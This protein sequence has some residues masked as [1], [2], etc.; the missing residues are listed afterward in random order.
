VFFVPSLLTGAGNLGA[1]RNWDLFAAPSVAPALCGIL[2]VTDRLGGREKRRLL[3]GLV[4][5]SLF[6]TVPWVALN[7]DFDRSVERIAALPLGLARGETL[8]G[9]Y[10]LNR[11][12]LGQ[13]ERWF[14]L[15][16]VRAPGNPSAES[17]LGLALAR[18]GRLGAALP[19]MTE[20]VRL[21]PESV[22][23]RY[24]LV[25]LLLSLERWEAAAHQ[26]EAVV[27][28][29]SRDREAWLGLADLRM[30]LGQPDTAAFVAETALRHYP[31]DAELL[32]TLADAQA[33]RV[34][35]HQGQGTSR[36]RATPSPCSRRR[37]PRTRGSDRCARLWRDG[38]GPPPGGA[39][40]RADQ[41][42]AR[43]V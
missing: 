29:D 10:H 13:A 2:L 30:R 40:S 14:R 32:R 26:L 1:A 3:L 25:N 28:L 4:A 9:T 39:D 17:G 11:G 31:D 24:D 36:G 34:V 12:E 42:L 5:V 21:K 22:E 38:R 33:L 8:L 23:M 7:A 19:A 35:K 41:N 20:A 18:Q 27:G 43:T 15:A 6:H 37:S 16:V